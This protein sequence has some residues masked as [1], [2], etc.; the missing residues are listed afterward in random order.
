MNN[1]TFGKGIHPEDMKEITEYKEIER[2][3][4]SKKMYIPLLQHIGSPLDAVV[5]IGDFVK[6]GQ[7]IGDSAAFMSAPIHSPVSGKVIAIG[8]HVFPV[9]GFVKTITIE[10]DE[11][12]EL[13]KYEGIDNYKDYTKENLLSIIRE[14]GL[15]GQGG[16]TFPTHI[17]LSPPKDKKIDT[18]L[19]NGAE[20][21]PYLNGDNR[22]MIEHSAE[23][24]Y[25]IKIMMYILE[26]KSAFIGIEANK[27]EAIMNMMEAL[28]NEQDIKVAVLETKYPQG[29]EKQ[30]IKAILKR[31]VPPKKL[32]AEVGVVVQ[33]LQ[34]AKSVYDAV[35]KGKP[36]IERVVTV[37]GGGV[38]NPGNYLVRIGTPFRELLEK[39]GYNHD[40]TKKIVMG[41]PMMGIAQYTID[42]PLVKGTSGILALTSEEIQAT[43]MHNCINC[44]KCI[45]VCPMN[46]MPQMFGKMAEKSKWDDLASYYVTDCMECGS[47]SYACPAK[48]PL[49]EAI[50]IG[51]T[52]M[53]TK[54]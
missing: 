21:E 32:P 24:I 43:K 28:K 30:L 1:L 40:K 20:C 13:E 41:G 49:N 35:V 15:V 38:S 51:K 17:K 52:I 19:I 39:A 45:E 54:K 37:S 8:T 46:L 25:G 4:A 26:V 48:R 12:D 29:G 47:C 27:P 34:T 53:R 36:L 7:K 9:S 14:R 2:F 44:G 11:K 23:C 50:K 6:M 22:T 3:P 16:A 18:L 33:N 42:V 31:E 5:K 10:N